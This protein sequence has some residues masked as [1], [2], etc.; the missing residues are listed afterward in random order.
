MLWFITS[1]AIVLAGLLVFGY[2]WS[3]KILQPKHRSKTKSP[4]NYGITYEEVK[5]KSQGKNLGGWIIKQP[6]GATVHRTPFVML[7]HGWESSAQG[8]LPHASYLFDHGYNL[9]MY[10]SRGHGDSDPIDFMSLIRF[11]EDAE[12][13]LE[14]L[15]SRADVD[16]MQMV[17]FGHSMGAAAAITLASRYK[18]I[19]AVVVSSTFSDFNEMV[20]DMLIEY[21]LPVW[22]IT[23]ILNFFWRRK[24]KVNF[25]DWNPSRNIQKIYSP[26][27]LAH[28]GQDETLSDSHFNELKRSVQS[29]VMESIFIPDGG[30]RNLFEFQDYRDAVVSF[31]KNHFF[32]PGKKALK[33]ADRND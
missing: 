28:G 26:I 8:M 22:P 5:F 4:A 10:D 13:A 6:N 20:R 2:Y 1:L 25:A 32:D 33:L 23:P 30:H 21:K 17:V 24:L 12:N 14:Y 16:P 15:Q 18:E 3:E 9:F 29:T 27:F 31:L 19:R 11:F 7:I